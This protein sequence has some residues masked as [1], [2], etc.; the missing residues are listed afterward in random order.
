MQFFEVFDQVDACPDLAEPCP[1]LIMAYVLVSAKYLWE[2]EFVVFVSLEEQNEW[3]QVPYD[4]VIVMNLYILPKVMPPKPHP[5]AF[6]QAV[7]HFCQSI[8]D[9]LYFDFRQLHQYLHVIV[10]FMQK[11]VPV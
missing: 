5:I 8:W 2:V 3:L 7:R 10:E 1:Y 11:L 9:Q 4:F 6:V